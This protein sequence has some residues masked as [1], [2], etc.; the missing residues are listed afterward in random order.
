MTYSTAPIISPSVTPSLQLDAEK[1]SIPPLA[2]AER[3]QVRES[4]QPA[5][6]SP[7]PDT[8]PPRMIAIPPAASIER[9]QVG[10]VNSATPS[11]SLQGD[12]IPVATS[13]TPVSSPPSA[14]PTDSQNLLNS[15]NSLPLINPQGSLATISPISV[16]PIIDTSQP[17]R[18]NI[19]KP[20]LNN[21]QKST[22]INSGKSQETTIE[23]P[24]EAESAQPVATDYAEEDLLALAESY[25]DQGRYGDAESLYKRF[26]AIRGK[27]SG[28]HH[29]EVGRC[30]NGLAVLYEEQGRY[31]EA[32]SLY[33]QALA[34]REQTLPPNHPDIATSLN[35]LAEWYRNQGRYAE[36][37]PLH[38]RALAIRIQ[39]LGPSHPNVAQS[40]NNLAA[41]YD[42]QGRDNEAEPLY[43]RAQ[44]IWTQTLGPNHPNVATVLGNLARLYGDQDRYRETVTLIDRARTIWAQTLEINQPVTGSP[45]SNNFP[46][47]YGQD[48]LSSRAIAALERLR[49][50]NAT[51]RRRL[52]TKANRLPT[53]GKSNIDTTVGGNAIGTPGEKTSN[54]A[55]GGTSPVNPLD[56][57]ATYLG[58]DPA[59]RPFLIAE[60]FEIGQL[61]H[62]E[63][64]KEPLTQAATRYAMANGP[65]L[66]LKHDYNEIL[67][68][69]EK[70]DT[71]L[72]A[73]TNQ[74]L[75]QSPPATK[76]ILRDYTH[77]LSRKLDNID[78]RVDREFPTYAKLTQQL[79]IS[80]E[81]L[82]ALLHPEE[83]LLAY[84]IGNGKGDQTSYVWLIRTNHASVRRLPFGNERLRQRIA[85]LRAQLNPEGDPWSMVFP[86]ADAYALF[87]DLMGPEAA[88]LDGIK[89]LFIVPD[90]ALER[91]PFSVLVTEPSPTGE[92][93]Y[94]KVAWLV[95]QWATVT[96]PSVASLRTLRAMPIAPKARE[97]FIGFGN[98]NLG[99]LPPQ[100]STQKEEGKEE[101]PPIPTN[102]VDTE[103]TGATPKKRHTRT[104]ASP[105]L[106]V[107]TT[108]ITVPAVALPSIMATTASVALTN[109]LIA[110]PN[111]LRTSLP[112]L[113]ETAD[114]M[115]AI[116]INLGA[117]PDGL[118]LEERA[119]V[120]MVRI[121]N[122]V[123][124]RVVAFATPVLIDGNF[125]G[126]AEPALVLT[127]PQNPTS[128]NDGLLRASQIARLRL[129]ADW[130]L[131]PICN[132]AMN[133]N[134]SKEIGIPGLSGLS[135]AF[136]QAGA[137]ALLVSHWPTRPEPTVALITD[138]LHTWQT[139]PELDRAAALR[140]S[141]ITFLDSPQTDPRY[142]HPVIWA[143][144]I[145]EG[146]NIRGRDTN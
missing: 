56:L 60:G 85:V 9:N 122:L 23:K 39:A 18:D 109:R 19:S 123:N 133:Q 101:T 102:T 13:L 68:I 142:L 76:R 28:L 145:I 38:Q 117:K 108:T 114:E 118:N 70:A 29:S 146:E 144:F 129:D 113:P 77:A 84:A 4:T 99:V 30:L 100:A 82:Q 5:P 89:T 88:R 135:K 22:A 105:I 12:S 2:S 78:L 50:I 25:D 95:R 31:Q 91:L 111:Q 57:L 71:E 36:A 59:L 64:I 126:L 46:T 45:E 10:E 110:D 140:H 47:N 80:L 20:L 3:N 127:P 106:K 119:S 107:V 24:A 128:D 21:I 104:K 1:V 34:I 73:I 86:V 96:L 103:I 37:E 65:L 75:D 98:P 8:T 130:V 97:S 32:E 81:Q 11:P 79:P 44:I 27:T 112:S 83:A 48:A 52:I 58:E 63:L 120:N 33:K 90:G 143:P 94:Q 134:A 40:L 125:E 115:K 138:M 17:G 42:D 72:L 124:Y 35:N 7:Q 66:V 121:A 131:L 62:D 15:T 26:L 55:R 14:T 69:W 132:T 6:I 49:Q 61:L 93:N 54:D 43:Q 87:Q 41:W 53:E 139:H 136:F 141:I 16:T 116:S 92:I 51:L 74:P 137:R 67:P